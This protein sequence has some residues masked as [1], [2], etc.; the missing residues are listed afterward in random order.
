MSALICLFMGH[1]W[2]FTDRF[3]EFVVGKGFTQEWYKCK[4]CFRIKHKDF[5]VGS[6]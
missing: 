6:E 2:V 5:Y 4:R 3:G 1:K